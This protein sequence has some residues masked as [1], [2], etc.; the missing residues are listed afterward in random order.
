MGAERTPGWVR[1]LVQPRRG[2]HGYPGKIE[3]ERHGTD[4]GLG[5]LTVLS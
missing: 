3:R 5:G 4:V 1:S 2:L